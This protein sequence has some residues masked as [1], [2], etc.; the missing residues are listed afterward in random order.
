MKPWN[1]GFPAVL[2]PPG[3]HPATMPAPGW[4]AAGFPPS[5]ASAV[6]FAGCAGPPGG[7][8][9]VAARRPMRQGMPAHKGCTPTRLPTAAA[10]CRDSAVRYLRSRCPGCWRLALRAGSCPD[11]DWYRSRVVRCS[12]SPSP[13]R[14]HPAGSGTGSFSARRNRK[15]KIRN[16]WHCPARQ[17]PFRKFPATVS[18]GWPACS[19]GKTW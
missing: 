18:P 3:R 14:I 9:T 4:V 11:Q 5:D 19:T 15:P 16:R 2:P 6:R 12:L 8:N 17:Y 13:T 7:C 1:A 10:Q